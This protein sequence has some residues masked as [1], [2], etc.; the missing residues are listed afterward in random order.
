MV[1]DLDDASEEGVEDEEFEEVVLA[2]GTCG[3]TFA[4]DCDWSPSAG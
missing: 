3:A 4:V 2:S 1:L